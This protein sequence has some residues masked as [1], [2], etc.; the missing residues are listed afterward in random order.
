MKGN[1]I[2]AEISPQC[3][4]HPETVYFL[5]LL[6]QGAPKTSKNRANNMQ[7]EIPPFALTPIEHCGEKFNTGAQLHLFRYRMALKLC[8][9]VQA[10][11]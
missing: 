2:P 4:G 5:Q 6:L 8:V 10:L 7:F 11:W 3:I 9:K 1:A